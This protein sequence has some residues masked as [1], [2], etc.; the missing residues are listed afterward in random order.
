MSFREGKSVSFPPQG[1]WRPLPHCVA[2]CLQGALGSQKTDLQMDGSCFSGLRAAGS[3]GL[4][5]LGT[6]EMESSSCVASDLVLALDL[7]V[8]ARYAP[9]RAVA[10]M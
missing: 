4:I 6:W 2:S 3:L 1:R 7:S 5:H 8:E 9:A 10:S